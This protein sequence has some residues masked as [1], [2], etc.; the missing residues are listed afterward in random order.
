MD[1]SEA[2]RRSLAEILA[3]QRLAFYDQAASTA[4]S[5]YGPCPW[6]WRPRGGLGGSPFPRGGRERTNRRLGA[7]QAEGGTC[8][9]AMSAGAG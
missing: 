1:I 5:G 8:H 2:R 3:V 7:R 4:T 9:L 6:A